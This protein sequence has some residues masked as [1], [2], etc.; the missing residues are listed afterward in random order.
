VPENIKLQVF[1][2]NLIPYPFPYIYVSNNE[3]SVSDIGDGGVRLNGN[4]TKQTY[5][6]F[7]KFW[8]GNSMITGVGTGAG[9]KFSSNRYNEQIKT[10]YDPA[11]QQ[12]YLSV[13]PGTV[14]DN[15]E[16]YPQIEIGSK[17]TEYEKGLPY[18]SF[19]PNTDGLVEFSSVSPTMSLIADTKGVVIDVEYNQDSNAVIKEL[20]EHVDADI[21][22]LDE[23]VDEIILS[24]GGGTADASN[25][26]T[27]TEVDNKIGDINTALDNLIALQESYIGG[28]E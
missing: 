2:K 25:Y 8:L 9:G 26:Y 24:G 1:G 6:M 20:S 5:V 11:D 15:I 12:L 22:K 28:V 21:Q 27:K 10:V 18:R 23:K 19:I 13:S 17:I 3:L 16:F 14:C 4:V 7:A